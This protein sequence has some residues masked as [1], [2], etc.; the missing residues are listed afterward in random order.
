MVGNT[1]DPSDCE[2]PGGSQKRGA[3][4]S[5]VRG[6]WLSLEEVMAWAA[7]SPGVVGRRA[8]EADDACRDVQLLWWV[9]RFRFVTAKVTAEWLGVTSQRANARVS[10]LVRLRLLVSY[11]RHVADP[12]AVYLTTAGAELLGLSRRR[13]PRLDIQ[14]EHEQAIVWMATRLERT[15]TDIR[16][17]TE[18]ECRRHDARTAM[19]HHRV[20]VRSAAATNA[21][22]GPTSSSNATAAD[23]DRDRALAQDNR[24]PDTHHPRLLRQQVQDRPL[25]RQRRRTP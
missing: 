15:A 16:V 11:R 20:D 12:R 8:W 2:G 6:S 7:A 24:A 4:M 21:T 19:S 18:R 9:G 25:L 10:R 5:G 1:L 14:R 13:R 22:A 23:R 17:L 3:G